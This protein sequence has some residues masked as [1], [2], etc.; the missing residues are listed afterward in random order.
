MINKKYKGL[1]TEKLPKL[2]KLFIKKIGVRRSLIRG[3]VIMNKK[4][5]LILFV[6]SGRWH[7]GIIREGVYK[8]LSIEMD[9]DQT[10]KTNNG[11][12]IIIENE[13]LQTYINNLDRCSNQQS[14]YLFETY[15][16]VQD[17][18]LPELDSNYR[19]YKKKLKCS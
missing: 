8:V 7:I 3:V 17:T 13:Y 15:G 9:S 11:W 5:E 1:D 18:P 19:N 6:W 16:L 12:R 4:S 14:R 2:K 10:Q